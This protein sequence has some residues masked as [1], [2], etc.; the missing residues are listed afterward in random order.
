M[1]IDKKNFI[2]GEQNTYLLVISQYLQYYI[3]HHVYL[4]NN[5]SSL[6]YRFRDGGI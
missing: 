3:I 4:K 2:K 5:L 1:M 6:K